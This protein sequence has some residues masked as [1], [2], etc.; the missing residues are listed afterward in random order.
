MKRR[1]ACI[2]EGQSERE[3]VPLLLRRIY[4]A[5]GDLSEPDVRKSDVVRVPRSRLLR[6][7]ELERLVQRLAR[8]VGPD[9]AIL[10]LIDADDDP[11]CTLAPTLLSR[12]KTERPDR[13]I[14]VVVAVREYEAWL[15]A[16]ARSLRGHCN[17]R[18]DLQPPEHPEHIRDAKSWLSK[19]MAR[20][21]YR[22]VLDQPRLT[23][24]M[25]LEEARTTRSFDKFWREIH[26]TILG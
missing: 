11:A 21:R 19:R 12:A 25:A 17:L 7:G 26:G 4:D 23:A 15:L 1:V 2:V 10:I 16:S 24:R 22:E 3:S 13:R 9:G 6:A 5:A 14:S 18:D 8:L 20:G